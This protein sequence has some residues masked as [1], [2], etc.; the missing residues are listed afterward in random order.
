VSLV[1][2][3]RRPPETADLPNVRWLARQVLPL[4]RNEFAL[5]VPPPCLVSAHTKSRGAVR[6]YALWWIGHPSPGSNFESRSWWWRRLP[7]SG[8]FWALAA[9]KYDGLVYLDNDTI[10]GHVF[11]QQHGSR[12]HA[13]S[14]AV[15]DGFEGAG[16]S[17]VM[18]LDF[19]A[20]AACRPGITA[21]RV[22]TGQ[23][24]TTRRLLSRL[25]RHADAVGWT[26]SEDG[27]VTFER[28]GPSGRPAPITKSPRHH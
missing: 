8:V 22:G 28:P 18:L 5:A 1:A 14:T 16:H 6:D 10:L 9:L 13:F 2:G 21:A 27:W 24:N 7:P 20:Y 23:N 11:F 17:V 12:L 19:V 26:V 15:H 3:E 25:R 4:E